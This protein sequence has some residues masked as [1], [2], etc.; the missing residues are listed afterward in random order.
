MKIAIGSNE[1]SNTI[2][3]KEVTW[4][5]IVKKYTAHKVTAKK[6]GEYVIG[7]EYSGDIRREEF[8]VGRSL[9][10]V[11]IDSYAGGIDDLAFDLSMLPF[12]FVAYSS[13]RHTS[14]KPRVR[15]IAQLARTVSPDE[16]RILSREV[17]AQMLV[18]MEAIDKCTFVPN[19]AMFAPQHPE[20]GEFWTMTQDGCAVSVPESIAAPVRRE[21]DDFSL[22]VA[23]R[24]L[25]LTDVEVRAYLAAYSPIG[26]DYD[27]WLRAG[28]AL[29]HQYS[30]AACA[31]DMWVEWSKQDAEKFDASVMRSKWKSFGGS[32]NPVTMASIIQHV[33]ASGGVVAGGDFFAR[34]LDEAVALET[35]E[36][37]NAFKQK[38]SAMT[39]S[40]LPPVH[41]SSIASEVADNF[42]RAHKVTKGAITK[43]L[44]PSKRAFGGV[45]NA[46][47]WVSDWVFVENQCA[48][49]KIDTSDY[50]ICRDSFNAVYDRQPECIAA[51]KHASQLALV[52]YNMPTVVDKMFFP[53]AAKF[54]DYEG[55]RMLN[56]F[57]TKGDAPIDYM[58]DASQQAVDI[59]LAHVR[60][61]LEHKKEQELFLDWMAYIYQN[62]GKRV[63]WAMLLQGSQ[64]TGKT[65]FANVFEQIM[66]T[67]VK[68]LDTPTISGRFTGW[69]A[70]AILNVVEEIRIVGQN[71]YEILDKLKPIISNSTI[72]IEEKG[73]DHRTV[74]NFTSY[75]LLTN[76]KDAVP[77]QD[78]DRRYCAFFSRVQ[79][80][81]QLYHELGG[82]DAHRE[83]FD[84]LFDSLK[85]NAGAIA[86]YLLDRVIPKSFDANGRA[87][88]TSARIEMKALSISPEWDEVDDAIKNN[89]CAVINDKVL[90]I[91]W[92]AKLI[93]G[94]GG[95]L[96]KTRAISAI[97]SEMGYSPIQGR[98]IKISGNS[99]HYVWVRGYQRTEFVEEVKKLVRV[100]HSGTDAAKTENIPF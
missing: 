3:H 54:F 97:L 82:I 66:G 4:Q 57:T 39:D 77:L 40:M 49:S 85:K 79:N 27:T 53:G 17:C 68:R 48:F 19:Q 61:T 30:G 25:E 41:R 13:Y 26:L 42:G 22:M 94:N 21:S 31:F 65:Y 37:F 34:L 32:T 64:G 96:P 16:Y 80:E 75:F 47:D 35:F 50:T 69:A 7:G 100:Y 33:N 18:P 45:E 86:R 63:S 38:I 6:G 10:V 43:E 51:E 60:F 20:G 90:D 23:A 89:Q 44:A 5:Q 73:R 9:L 55:K 84:T 72:Q 59:F 99:Q 71:R 56:S 36:D 29:W 74:P 88:E 83:Y 58:D 15:V 46:P 78:G 87:P 12:G 52:N 24:P 98:K 70:G 28:M 1:T 91:T 62:P 67:N 76:H 2:I 81:E 11:D 8:L 14:E 95:V 93:G 92:L